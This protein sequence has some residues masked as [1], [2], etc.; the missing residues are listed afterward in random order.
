[1]EFE[2]PSINKCWLTPIWSSHIYANYH[3]YPINMYNYLK[4]THTHTHKECIW[5]CFTNLPCGACFRAPRAS[6][7]CLLQTQS[8]WHSYDR[9]AYAYQLIFHIALSISDKFSKKKKKILSNLPPLVPCTQN[10]TL[11]GECEPDVLS[12]GEQ[13]RQAKL[14]IINEDVTSWLCHSI[15]RRSQK[16]RLSER[17]KG[18]KGNTDVSTQEEEQRVGWGNQKI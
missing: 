10:S 18:S 6:E 5:D 11:H 16:N 8:L 17:P 1:M 14:T 9:A 15:L 12:R 2:V 13:E 3:I 4:N 7:E